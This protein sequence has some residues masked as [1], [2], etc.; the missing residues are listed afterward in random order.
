M[1]KVIKYLALFLFMTIIFGNWVK[2]FL[3]GW[4]I[5][6]TVLYFIVEINENN[7]LKAGKRWWEE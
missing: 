1:G 3:L 4:A 5:L 6:V 7:R 2:Y